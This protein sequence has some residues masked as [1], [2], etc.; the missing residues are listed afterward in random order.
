[1][2]V[3]TGTQA[4]I[5]MFGLFKYVHL[6]NTHVCNYPFLVFVYICMYVCTQSCKPTH[7]E[8]EQH[9]CHCNP[10]KQ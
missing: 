3:A 1:M 10:T 9:P 8:E 4:I 2:H 7:S 6:H 5:S